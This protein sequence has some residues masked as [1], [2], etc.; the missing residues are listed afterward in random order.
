M[1]LLCEFCRCTFRGGWQVSERTKERRERERER[2]RDRERD[3]WI[4]IYIYSIYSIYSI[5]T[6]YI[7]IYTWSLIAGY[8]NALKSNYTASQRKLLPIDLL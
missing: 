6:I 3:V 8:E 4:Y 7:Y 1:G 5:Y 2:E